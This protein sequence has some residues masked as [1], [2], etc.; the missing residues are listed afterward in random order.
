MQQGCLAQEDS[1][2]AH[3]TFASKVVA[4]HCCDHGQHS[5]ASAAMTTQRCL[6]AKLHSRDHADA[7][8][9]PDA[10]VCCANVRSVPRSMTDEGG[11]A[12]PGV[13]RFPLVPKALWRASESCCVGELLFVV[14]MLAFL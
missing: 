2:Q 1:M 3:R 13:P 8:N 9:V 4:C 10:T 14:R 7:S 12:T 5:E 6:V 11:S